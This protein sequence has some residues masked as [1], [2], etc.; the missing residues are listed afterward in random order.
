MLRLIVPDF[1]ARF[2]TETTANGQ[3]AFNEWLIGLIVS[4]LSIGTLIGA[5]VGAPIAD[6]L[7]RRKAIFVDCIV[8][9]IGVIIQVTSFQAW[10]QYGIGRFVTGLGVGALS[11]IIPVYQSEILPRQIRGAM[12]AAYQFMITLGILIADVINIVSCYYELKV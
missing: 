11:A 5:L 10:Y 4:L 6:T 3:P 1:I 8:F 9:H 12:V 7:G 2:G